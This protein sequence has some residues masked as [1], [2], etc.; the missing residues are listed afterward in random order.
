MEWKSSYEPKEHQMHPMLISLLFPLRVQISLGMFNNSLLAGLTRGV[1][2]IQAWKKAL[3]WRGWGWS[4]PASPG[5]VENK[6]EPLAG[7]ELHFMVHTLYPAPPLPQSLLPDPNLSRGKLFLAAQPLEFS[8]QIRVTVSNSG[9]A[10]LPI[11]PA[12]TVRQKPSPGALTPIG[13]WT[14]T[15]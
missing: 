14:G 9:L 10:R 2:S 11:L 7:A 13:V 6:H 12:P 4:M 8:A 1:T 15:R 5:A 3:G